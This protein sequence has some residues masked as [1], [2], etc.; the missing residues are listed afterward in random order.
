[1]TSGSLTITNLQLEL[2][3]TITA[4]EQQ[5]KSYAH[6]P[7]QIAQD[8]SVWLTPNA[9]VYKEEWKKNVVLDGSLI[10]GFSLDFAGFKAVRL[11]TFSGTLNTGD[12]NFYIVKPDGNILRN[13]NTDSSSGITSG[14]QA[15]QYSVDAAFRFSIFDIDSGWT[16]AMTPSNPDIQAYFYGWKMCASDG[17]TYVSGTKY[18]KKITDGT[19]ITATLP[20]ASY[21]GYTP[22]VLHYKLVT[23]VYHINYYGNDPTK[24][25]MS[26]GSVMNIL[27]GVTQIEQLSGVHFREKGNPGLSG[28]KYFIN[29]TNVAGSLLSRRLKNKIAV[30]MNGNIYST[31]ETTA[32]ANAYG[33]YYLA[34]L[35]TIYD[36]TATY[37]VT[38][39]QLD[40]YL[41]TVDTFAID[42]PVPTRQRN[43][44]LDSTEQ[45]I[46][47]FK[48]N[49]VDLVGATG[50]RTP[51]KLADY[52]ILDAY[53]KDVVDGKLSSANPLA[54]GTV[55]NYRDLAAYATS[56]NTTGT[57][58]I[59]LP[60]SWA[61][62]M[63]S[64]K[65]EGYNHMPYASNWEVTVSGYNSVSS[66]W[67]AYT[68]TLSPNCP[69]TSVRFGYDSM[70]GKNCILL[71]TISLAMSNPKIVVREMLASWGG[72]TSYSTGW[73]IS[74][75]PDESNITNIVTP[76][77]KT[78]ATLEGVRLTPITQGYD[79]NTLLIPNKYLV[80]QPVNGPSTDLYYWEID[81]SGG[82]L[83]T[84][85]IAVK[86]AT[87]QSLI[88]HRHTV[89][90]GTTWSDWK[91]IAMTDSPTFT[92]TTAIINTSSSSVLNLSRNQLLSANNTIG[93]IG[94][95]GGN[96]AVANGIQYAGINVS[97]SGYTSGS[98]SSSLIFSNRTNGSI[99]EKVY[100][101]S[102]GALRPATTNAYTLGATSY[103]WSQ[104]Y[105]AT[106]TINTSDR[107]AKTDIAD[108]DLGLDFINSLRPV[109]FK[110]KVRQNE[111]IA[112]QCGVE[113][114]EIEPAMFDEEGNVIIPAVTEERPVYKEVVTPLPG[115]R[116]HAGLIAQDVEEALNGK[117][118]GIFTVD[119][120]GSYGLRYEEFIA[121]LVKA[122][123]ELSAKVERL[124]RE[125]A[126]NKK[127]I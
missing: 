26:A 41:Y 38:Y 2:G 100:I 39:E 71:G 42:N 60:V 121:P 106:A 17:G 107:N 3:S 31:Y 74:I 77:I 114:V 78:L 110:Y 35:N 13:I 58:K 73:D 47:Y 83:F 50:G 18:W 29:N 108:L 24:P 52:G 91:Q 28:T 75:T 87:G 125:L 16:D 79:L 21:A 85:Q 103:L 66:G 120:Q 119:D 92:G 62:T 96:S 59:L 15:F 82:S 37:T 57:I 72:L 70:A 48:I 36:S 32:G 86:H 109:E 30:Y 88:Y 6:T 99:T 56:S 44:S 112:E 122:V 19:G 89:N 61:N 105:A 97:T 33:N 12:F 43:F 4:F 69:F 1:M 20:T 90:S 117:D 9:S 93:Y 22:Y 116:T 104:L 25:I 23:P 80:S 101:D 127:A 102:N 65:I 67:V 84:S 49:P 34:I 10:Y 53:T 113:T 5:V 7:M 126:S 95:Y 40:K 64:I 14:D 45:K 27:Q 81:V 51:S 46:A 68:A 54:S 115:V 11:P 94:V 123:Q 124:E 63:M 118:V 76:T 98:E 55:Y 8:E 111:V